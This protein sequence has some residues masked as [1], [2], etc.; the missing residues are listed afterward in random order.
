MGIN[1]QNLCQKENGFFVV[2][3]PC[4]IGARGLVRATGCCLPVFLVLWYLQGLAIPT[5]LQVT[6]LH[7]DMDVAQSYRVKKE[8]YCKFCHIPL[9]WAELYWLMWTATSGYFTEQ[10]SI[11]K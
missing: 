2:C 7:S 5:R 11:T 1:D 8:P 10:L 4:S 6:I 9:K 3:G